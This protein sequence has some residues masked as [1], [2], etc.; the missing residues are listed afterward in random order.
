MKLYMKVTA[1]ELE[2][3]LLIEDNL[4]RFCQKL[5]I[6]KDRCWQIICRD[7]QGSRRGY[8]IVRIN[9]DEDEEE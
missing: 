3:P 2:L 1:D 7:K 9:V 5:G 8:R 4:E 6:S